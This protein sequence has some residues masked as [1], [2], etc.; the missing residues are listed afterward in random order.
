M[1]TAPS[2][3]TRRETA[4]AQAPRDAPRPRWRP[5]LILA[6]LPMGLLL[7]YVGILGSHFDFQIYY[8]ALTDVLHGGSAYDFML[9]EP[10]V[11]EAMGF[12]YPPF[13]SLVLLPLGL[14]SL[15]AAGVVMSVLTTVL[16]MAAL[17]G[18]LVVVD[19][20][21]HA[22]GRGRLS[23][24]LAILAPLPLACSAA[25]TSN[26]SLG[27]L[28]FVVGAL[29]LLDVT[30]LPRRW[31][32]A[33]VGLAG[34]LKLTP[35][36]L[37]PYFLITRQWRAALN[38]SVAFGAATLVSAAVRWSDSLR[39]WL[40]PELVRTSLGELARVDNWSING[41]VS[42][43]GFGATPRTVIWLVLAAA[44]LLVAVWRAGL[45]HGAG[46]DLEA[47]LVMGLAAALVAAATWPHHMLYF[48]VAGVLLSVQRPLLGFPLMVAFAVG[49]Y[50]FPD[51]VGV[52]VVLVMVALVVLGLPNPPPTVVAST[53]PPDG[54]SDSAPA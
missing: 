43:M 14:L 11:N 32:G 30:V 22:A 1:T 10:H 39:Y 50:V 54:E 7:L 21:L 48:L 18:C 5:D 42:L 33:L 36:I 8:G 25:A 6:V 17:L 26:M 51:Q 44:V 19:G 27:Q 34:A 40:H 53:S 29:V 49:G 38:A 2:S 52:F 31:R 4:E 12:V 46:Q 13:A 20:R 35:L 23:P 45:H 3:S 41:L 37:V 9:V 28:S 16:V 47:V 15:D 24:I